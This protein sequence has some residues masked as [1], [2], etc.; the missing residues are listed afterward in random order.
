[1]GHLKGELVRVTEEG[2]ILK[3]PPRISSRMQREIRA[4]RPVIP[5]RAMCRCLGIHPTAMLGAGTR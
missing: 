1:M 2:D 4:H 3:K 5:V